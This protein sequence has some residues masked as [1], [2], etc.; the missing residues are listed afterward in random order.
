MIHQMMNKTV[1]YAFI[2]LSSVLVSVASNQTAAVVA[3]AEAG[4]S[5]E[6][7]IKA[8]ACTRGSFE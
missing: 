4:T 5:A 8:S 3:S 2:K 1:G 7:G 6:I